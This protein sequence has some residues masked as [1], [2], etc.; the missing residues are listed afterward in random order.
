MIYLYINRDPDYRFLDVFPSVVSHR[1][2]LYPGYI[3]NLYWLRIEVVK[4]WEE[5]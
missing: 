5:S 1:G 4:I 3:L 2:W